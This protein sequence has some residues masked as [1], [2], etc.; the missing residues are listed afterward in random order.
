MCDIGTAVSKMRE[1]ILKKIDGD[2]IIPLHKILAACGKSMYEKFGLEHWHPFMDIAT[3]KKLMEKKDLYGIYQN[4]IAVATF[5]LSIESRDYYYDELWS[6]PH[7]QAIYLGQLG[8][9][10]TLQGKGLGKWCMHQVEEITKN[11]GRKA[12]RF[13]GLSLHPWL[14]IFYEKLDY[15]PRGIVKPKQWDLLC[16]EKILK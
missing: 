12:I 10:P 7:E 16:F 14:K 2:A 3:F 13:D 8:I 1:F 6:N 4:G 11:M 9:D 5:N 15:L